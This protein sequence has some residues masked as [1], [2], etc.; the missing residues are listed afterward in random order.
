[1]KSPQQWVSENS[2]AGPFDTVNTSSEAEDLVR[3][4]QQDATLAQRN[5]LLEARF[6]IELYSKG[7]PE[8]DR[9]IA[10]ITNTLIQ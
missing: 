2:Q 3:S 4:I 6:F 9:I 7:T 5:A 8:G 1:M 10:A